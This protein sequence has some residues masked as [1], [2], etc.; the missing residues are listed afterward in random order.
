MSDLTIEK[1]QNMLGAHADGVYRFEARCEDFAVDLAV[2]L[3]A[4]MR[5]EAKIIATLQ[6]LMEV[7]TVAYSSVG[8]VPIFRNCDANMLAHLLQAGAEAL[9]PGEY[10]VR[11]EG[12]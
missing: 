8:S 10:P 6:Q 1:L 7:L 12:K 9:N 3:L 4:T 2:Q 5:R 11:E